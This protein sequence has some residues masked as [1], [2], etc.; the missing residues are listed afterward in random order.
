MIWLAVAVGGGVGALARHA[1]NTAITLRL[2]SPF[3][4]GIFAVNILGCAAIGLVAGTV[5][6]SRLQI[7]ETSRTFL[8]AGVL[9]G[10]T[11]FSSF[12]LDTY[13]LL[14]GG[15]TA[16]ALLNAIGQVVGGLAAVWIGFAVANR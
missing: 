11:T 5:A 15:H 7:G 13:T 12:S 1:L 10:F 2:G 14:R 8:V 16:S 9:G 4:V 6:S 3:P